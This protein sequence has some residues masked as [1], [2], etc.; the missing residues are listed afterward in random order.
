[1]SS[2]ILGQEATITLADGTTLEV[3]IANP[4]MAR[5]DM[6]R[7]TH[8]W[9]TMEEAPVLWATFVAWHASKRQGLTAVTFDAWRDEV[10]LE[11]SMPQAEEAEDLAVDPTP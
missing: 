7:H 5:W 4:D 3:V 6:T 11:V 2:K 10:C 1:M 9:P 8:K